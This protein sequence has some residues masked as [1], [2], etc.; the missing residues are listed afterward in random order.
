MR[1]W[2]NLAPPDDPGS[3]YDV[4]GMWP[5]NRGTYE[6]ADFIGAGTAITAT[7][8]GE[9]AHAWCGRGTTAN[10]ELLIDNGGK[11]WKYTPE[12]PIDPSLTDVTGTAVVGHCYQFAQ[13]G[14]V[15]IG[16]MGSNE[17]AD[18]VAL[19]GQ[20]TVKATSPGAAFS[21]LAGAPKGQSICVQANA[22]LIFNT[23][24]ANDGWATSDVGD[25]TN[26]ATGEAASGRIYM[27]AGPIRA[28]V[29][30]GTDVFAFKEYSIHRMRY[31]GGVVKWIVEKVWDGVGCAV[32]NG[33]IAGSTGILFQGK[34]R[35]DTGSPTTPYYWF[36]GVNPPRLVNPFT[37]V[38]VGPMIYYPQKNIFSVWESNAVYWYAPESG[39]W[40]RSSSPMTSPPT[41]TAPVLGEYSGRASNDR[42]LTTACY[43]KSAANTIKRFAGSGTTA[44]VYLET[45]KIGEPDKKL[46][47]SR[48][49]PL[50][51]RRVDLG[52]DSVTATLT[53]FREREDTTA[54]TTRAG[55]AESTD[56]KRFDFRGGTSA[57]NFARIKVIWTA[58]DV[59][60]DDFLIDGNPVRG[61]N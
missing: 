53:L 46:Q 60:V 12:D 1:K 18:G 58:L 20:A 14:N 36:D 35:T 45:T 8:A 17:T 19:G 39:M 56:R 37:E 16:V 28:G 33:A 27:P 47:L 51:R 13:F 48:C 55:I 34:S 40:G 61:A 23:D 52:T 4:D 44:A 25:Y 26:W 24:T 57:D 42:G 43:G 50:L 32:R 31:V 10:N 59:E 49:I 6:T 41:T 15:T 3:W 5:T 11:I 38:G 7:G 54:Q 21:A 9:I 22:V 29:S 30:F 2:Q